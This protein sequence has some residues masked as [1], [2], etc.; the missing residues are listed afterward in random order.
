[1]LEFGT[2]SR[3]VHDPKYENAAKKALFS[4]WDL[5]SSLDLLGNSFSMTT[6]KWKHGVSGIGAG[7]DSF[8]EY[9]FKSYILFG[10]TSY[11]DMFSVAYNAVLNYISLGNGFLYANV[12]M[13]TG[14]LAATWV[15]SLSAF[16]P[17]LQVLVGDI[18]RAIPHHLF[19]DAIWSRYSAIPERFDVYYQKTAIE[20]Y[21]LR[22]EFIE[23]TYMLYQATKDDYYLSVGERILNDLEFNCKTKCGVAGLKDVNTG[24]L[25]DRMESFFLSETLKYLYLLFDKE[26]I[27]NSLDGNF[28]FSTEGHILKLNSK[29]VV[30]K[31]MALTQETCPVYKT[32]AIST[33]PD[34]IKAAKT[35]VGTSTVAPIV[36]AKSSSPPEQIMYDNDM[37]L[38]FGCL[39][40]IGI[41][42]FYVHARYRL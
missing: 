34:L 27:I 39:I 7:V 4:V 18:S 10:D 28:V 19:F 14:K 17:G 15:D 26:N 22:P 21:P 41:M 20:S 29:Q 42:A 2:L 16:F 25:D 12:D 3:L 38:L 33:F 32:S 36:F 13:N 37:W 11:L 40:Q 30:R 31:G 5:R 1:M 6:L 35:I 23:S 8:Y 9:L 24:Q